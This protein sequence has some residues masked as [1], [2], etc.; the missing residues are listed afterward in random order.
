MPENVEMFMYPGS[1]QMDLL[2]PE[3]RTRSVM[4]VPYVWVSVNGVTHSHAN[5]QCLNCGLKFLELKRKH[6]GHISG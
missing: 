6:D 2:C 1:P 5:V 4:L 3:C